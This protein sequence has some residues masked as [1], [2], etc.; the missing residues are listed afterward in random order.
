MSSNV[1]S[2][3]NSML[4]TFRR[5]MIPI[6]GTSNSNDNNNNNTSNNNSSNNNTSSTSSTVY[7]KNLLAGDSR[8]V[9]M[10]N[11]YTNDYN[12][13]QYSKGGGKQNNK[14]FYIGEIGMGYTWFMSTALPA[15]KDKAKT[16]S[17]NIIIMIGGND[18]VS[19]DSARIAEQYFN[20]ISKLAKGDWKNQNIVF[21]SVNPFIETSLH[22][23]KQAYADSFNE[24]IK[25]KINSANIANLSYCDTASSLNI[26][27]NVN[28]SDGAHYNSETYKKIYNKI[29][30]DC[31]K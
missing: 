29:F 13:C 17:Y 25:S 5:L 26:S 30:T 4:S 22:N 11:T 1:M 15:L 20:E 18:C 31:V 3:M 21:V 6:S 19:S 24:K 2:F 23:A 7:G 9:G 28:T 10:C 8:T 12:G 16:G 14:D 27:L